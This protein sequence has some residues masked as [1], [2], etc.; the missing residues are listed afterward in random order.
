LKIVILSSAYPPQLD[1]IGDHTG[2][3]GAELAVQGHEVTVITAET[4]NPQNEPRLR[5]VPCFD[6]SRS[7]T[8]SRVPGAIAEFCP[9]VDWVLL[10]HNPFGFG[11]RGWA[12]GLPRLLARLKREKKLRIA[13]MFHE[14]CVPRIWGKFLLMWLWQYPQFRRVCAATDVAFV[15][16]TRWQSEISRVRPDLEIH[17]LPVGSNIP[18]CGVSREE[19]RR[20]LGIPTD[21]IVVGC[22][23]SA[24]KSRLITWIRDAVENL[25]NLGLRPVMMYVG[26]DSKIVT[27]IFPPELLRDEGIVSAPDA[28]LRIKSM[29]AVLTPFV[30]GISTRRTSAIAALVNGVPIFSTL[31][32]HSD[33][34]WASMPE[35]CGGLSNIDGGSAAFSDMVIKRFCNRVPHDEEA[36]QSFCRQ[37][38]WP[39]IASTMISNLRL[40]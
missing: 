32:P 39:E 11:K 26:P 37:F 27:G 21:A 31:A 17:H 12:P 18:M 4:H 34:C 7:E 40:A 22:F 5:L 1:G 2:Q 16:T 28:A 35:A 38:R 3:L 9:D 29:D 6:S 13:V 25:K 36:F 20:Q 24:H 8:L 23:G 10:Q 19:A 30:D 14:T 33:A 15:S